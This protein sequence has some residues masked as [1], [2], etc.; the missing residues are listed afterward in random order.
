M[1]EPIEV[2]VAR[3]EEKQDAQI[4][5]LARIVTCL[6]GNGRDGMIVEMDRL[7][8]DAERRRWAVRALAASVL[9]VAVKA[10]WGIFQ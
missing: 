4:A 9:T 5:M 8:Q 10:F 6:E 2:V 3:L 7:K 1:S